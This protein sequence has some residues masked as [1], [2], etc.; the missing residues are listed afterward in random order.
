MIRTHTTH[1]RKHLN[2]HKNHA[3]IH[4]THTINTYNK[5]YG[6]VDVLK[7]YSLT[8]FDFN[9]FT[10]SAMGFRCIPRLLLEHKS[11][12][13][14]KREILATTIIE[15]AKGNS[16]A[17]FEPWNVIFSRSGRNKSKKS[18]LQTNWWTLDKPNIECKK[19]KNIEKT[20][21]FIEDYIICWFTLEKIEN[22]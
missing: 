18:Q 4:F 19:M 5:I 8:L 21:I 13:W 16:S 3:H 11:E 17:D 7:F 20:S 22:S 10:T 12:R 6:R 2:T 1:A 14:T 9:L 15:N